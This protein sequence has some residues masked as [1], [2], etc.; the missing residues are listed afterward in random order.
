MLRNAF[1][2]SANIAAAPAASRAVA[3]ASQVASFARTACSAAA[4][5]GAGGGGGGL[6]Q[7][8]RVKARPSAA[9]AVLIASWT[10][11][12]RRCVLQ[13]SAYPGAASMAELAS[14]C[15]NHVQEGLPVPSRLR[16]SDAV[17]LLQLC[18]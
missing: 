5:S 7:A 16:R 8:A 1:P 18:D 9:T 14:R 13:C 6:A 4:R 11:E 15:P 17:D 2:S 10:W 3:A 12:L